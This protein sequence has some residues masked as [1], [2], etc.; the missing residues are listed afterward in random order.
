VK[1]QPGSSSVVQSIGSDLAGIGYSGIGYKTSEVRALPLAAKTG[2]KFVEADY[3]NCLSGAY[4]MA[5]FL[6]VYINK[7][8]GAPADKLVQ[9]FVKYIQSKEGQQVVVKD[10]Y[11]PLPAT[12][13]AEEIVKVSK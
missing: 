12:V 13:T 2:G 8:P 7:K 9:E 1:E 4:P 3:E 6:Y 11:F 10:G 5:R